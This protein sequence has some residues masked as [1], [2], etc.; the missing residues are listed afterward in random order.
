ME[1]RLAFAYGRALLAARIGVLALF[2]LAVVTAVVI[3]PP[4]PIESVAVLSAVIAAYGVMF[5]LSPLL[6]EH[7][8]TRSRLILR[9][10]WYFRTII[11]FAEIEAIDASD[12]TGPLRV[13]L[14]IHRPLGQ[15]ALF[16][17]GGRTNLVTVRLRNPMRFWQSFGLS[18]REIVFDVTDRPRFFEAFEE[19]R[20]LLPP[21]EPERPYA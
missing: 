18:V 21:V 8:L 16:V 20:S 4:I 12:R 3:L 1:K 17:T 5:V 11:P 19:R 2:V 9:Q 7:W 14:G 13:P 15:P 6:T 10:G